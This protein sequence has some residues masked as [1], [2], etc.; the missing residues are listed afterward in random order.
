MPTLQAGQTDTITLAA[1]DQLGNPITLTPDAPP[2]WT[3]SDPTKASSAV[4]AD[5]MSNVVTALAAGSTTIGVS[6]TVNSI[7]FSTS[8]VETVV[9]ASPNIAIADMSV[10]LTINGV[11]VTYN[12]SD[13]IAEADY[14]PPSWIA[15]F[16][17]HA[18]HIFDS[19]RSIWVH[20]RSDEETARPEIVFEYGNAFKPI[21]YNASK[22]WV[23]EPTLTNVGV[24]ISVN[25][26]VVSTQTLA[27]WYWGTSWRYNPLPRPALDS[28]RLWLIANNKVPPLQKRDSRQVLPAVSAPY[29]GP[30]SPAGIYLSMNTTGERKDIGVWNEF[31]AAW[32]QTGDAGMLKSMLDWAEG[33]GAMN[34]HFRDPATAAP[35]NPLTY[36]HMAFYFDQTLSQLTPKCNYKSSAPIQFDDAHHPD[37]CTPAFLAT[38]DR[39]FAE[40]QQFYAVYAFKSLALSNFAY[41]PNQ[42]RGYAW[43][44]RTNEFTR[45]I[46]ASLTSPPGML[47]SA[48][49][50][51][52]HDVNLATLN[53]A[54]VNN[55]TDPQRCKYF[56]MTRVADLSIAYWMDDYVGEV[57]GTLVHM[58]KSEFLPALLWKVKANKFRTSGTSGW[59]RGD[60]TIY[61]V[62]YRDASGTIAP[63]LATLIADNPNLAS[64]SNSVLDFTSNNGQTKDYING[65]RACLRLGYE[66]GGDTECQAMYQWLE[67][68]IAANPGPIA[69]WRTNF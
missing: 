31:A 54:F 68:A 29:T 13:A 64:L 20:F 23:A 41:N 50:D 1:V 7:P 43:D 48:V 42:V 45:L 30:M 4:A 46:T 17:Q 34:C 33:V 36:P 56:C 66:Q 5:H 62:V 39:Y 24:S 2:T 32:L 28:V 59:P 40:R 55:T 15:P 69:T 63:D 67:T 52:F 18:A 16:T 38:G 53:S 19:A 60:N 35:I 44:M 57:L 9:A 47:P 37:L 26:S 11:P 22:Q 58:G 8:S 61:H 65:N 12:G 21:T 51:N 14:T 10:T 6:L 25:G 49:W 3:N 27:N